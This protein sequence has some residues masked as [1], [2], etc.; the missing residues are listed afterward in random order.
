MAFT[1]T[2]HGFFTHNMENLLGLYA[3]KNTYMLSNLHCTQEFSSLC[4][5]VKSTK[6]TSKKILFYTDAITGD[7]SRTSGAHGTTQFLTLWHNYH[8]PHQIK[9]ISE[10]PSMASRKHHIV[11]LLGFYAKKTLRPT[12]QVTCIAPQ[13]SA[14][15]ALL[16]NRQCLKPR[17]SSSINVQLQ[18]TVPNHVT[19]QCL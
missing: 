19:I 11:Q 17:N 2:I 18:E 16:D 12:S 14:G 8:G 4:T 10:L 7:S 6:C 5:I 3:T 15:C 9:Q 1:K 13:H